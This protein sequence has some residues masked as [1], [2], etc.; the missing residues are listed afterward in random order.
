MRRPLVPLLPALLALSCT[1]SGSGWTYARLYVLTEY[2]APPREQ[3]VQSTRALLRWMTPTLTRTFEE[4]HPLTPDLKALNAFVTGVVGR[5]VKVSWDLLLIFD[6]LGR[7]GWELVSG[8]QF[9]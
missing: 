6:A 3:E 5:P 7:A 2:P 9:H 4:R 8:F 1:A